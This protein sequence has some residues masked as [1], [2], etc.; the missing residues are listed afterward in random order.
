MG[1]AMFFLSNSEDSKA[2]L[3]DSLHC[4]SSEGHVKLVRLLIESG[5]KVESLSADSS[6]TL[7]KACKR[8]H[9]EV[10]DS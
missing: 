4:A 7:Q 8:G 2:A 10:T 3:D 6:N 5:A 1:L 9:L